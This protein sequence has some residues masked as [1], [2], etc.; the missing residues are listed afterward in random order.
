MNI[1]KAITII[2][3][4]ISI[5]AL[6]TNGLLI[7]L[8]G[9]EGVVVIDKYANELYENLPEDSKIIPLPQAPKTIDTKQHSKTLPELEERVVVLEDSYFTMV[10]IIQVIV[11]LFIP[12]LMYRF[13]NRRS[14]KDSISELLEEKKSKE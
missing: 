3:V 13:R 10:A 6:Y 4:M 14:I 1:F 11:P 9:E 7:R 2:C 12:A 8:F 5:Y